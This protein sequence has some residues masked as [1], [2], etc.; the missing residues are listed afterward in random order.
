MRAMAN[1]K[2]DLKG[3]RIDAQERKPLIPLGQYL[4]FKDA[5][6]KAD[7]AALNQVIVEEELYIERE[8]VGKL[9]K[10]GDLR[11]GNGFKM[12]TQACKRRLGM[13]Q[14]YREDDHSERV[15]RYSCC[16][17][18]SM[19]ADPELFR[20]I[21]SVSGYH[22]IG[23]TLIAQYL[24]NKEDGAENGDG[25]GVD[26]TYDELM[27]LRLSHVEAGVR[28]VKLYASCM[29]ECERNLTVWI[30]G[31]HHMAQNGK[32]SAIG[33][34]YYPQIIM[35]KGMGAHM[36]GNNIP[37]V[38]RIV[39]CADIYSAIMEN[40]FYL[41]KSKSIVERVEGMAKDDAALGPLISVAGT[42]VDPEMVKYLIMGRYDVDQR[43]AEAIVMALA[44]REMGVLE[45]RGG[46]ID[47]SL[48]HVLS[49]DSFLDLIPVKTGQWDNPMDTQVLSMYSGA[50][51]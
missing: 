2:R 43:D 30:V 26:I 28:F 31:G 22:D 15:R 42:D 40:R 25:K 11:K 35:Q 12:F 33:R 21:M 6:G 18:D 19:D 3:R 7:V 14:W 36:K 1:K 32:G 38:A 13:P 16:I 46:D 29:T 5:K 10:S 23:K 50:P 8:I 17:A 51:A 39:R 4:K 44:C 45:E 48:D 47:F 20:I 24:M 41:D 27:V 34:G 37:L 49:D 9:M